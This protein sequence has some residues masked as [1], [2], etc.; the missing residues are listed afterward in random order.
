[1]KIE[2][3]PVCSLDVRHSELSE[4]DEVFLARLPSRILSIQ[5]GEWSARLCN[6]PRDDSLVGLWLPEGSVSAELLFAPRNGDCGELDDMRA[7]VAETLGVLS[8]RNTQMNI[9]LVSRIQD[10][11]VDRLYCC[12][13]QSEEI[14]RRLKLARVVVDQMEAIVLE[15]RKVP[16]TVI[17][18]II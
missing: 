9:S 7:V 11:R 6:A 4:V 3:Y 18:F 8:C 2:T 14:I 16:E 13:A 10:V 1:M 17:H 5:E 15:E 12:P